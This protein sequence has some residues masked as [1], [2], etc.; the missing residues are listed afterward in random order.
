[1]LQDLNQQGRADAAAYEQSLQDGEALVRRMADRDSGNHP[2]ALNAYPGAIVLFNNLAS[3]PSMTFQCPVDD[4]RLGLRLNWPEP[5]ASARPP[6]GRATTHAK[7]GA[8]RPLPDNVQGPRRHRRDIRDYAAA[9]RVLMSD[10]IELGD[11]SIQVTRKA[12]KQRPFVCASSARPGD[13][14]CAYRHTA[15]G[16]SGLRHIQSWAGYAVSR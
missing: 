14:G 5:C 13:A 11:I 12:I 4:A 15:G 10:T 7:N 2:D 3:I 9:A 8:Q 6:A 16:R 1:M